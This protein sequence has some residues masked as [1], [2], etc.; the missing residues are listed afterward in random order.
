MS[1]GPATKPGSDLIHKSVTFVVPGA[2]DQPTGGYRYDGRVVTGLRERGWRVDVAE[3]DGR[4]PDPDDIA[5][6]SLDQALG[7]AESG[8]IVIVDGLA[9]SGLPDVVRR[10]SHRLTILALIHHALA[11][12]AGV[13]TTN[14]Q[15]WIEPERRA[16]A[17]VS[18]VVTTS[19]YTANRLQ[20]LGL[21]TSA[22]HV[23]APGVDAR[24]PATPSLDPPI[25]L[26][27]VASIIPRKNHAGL[28]DALAGIR[29]LDW[30]CHLAGSLG[31]SPETVSEVLDRVKRHALEQR[32]RLDGELTA[33]ALDSVYRQTDLFVLASR[34]EGFGMVVT[35]A[36]A[37]GLPLVTTTG[38]ALR[39]TVPEKA[40]LTV[41]P[42]DTEALASALRRVLTDGNLFHSLKA[43]ATDARRRLPSWQSCAADFQQVLLETSATND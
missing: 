21:L 16:L 27:C 38:G 25:N 42:D 39:D 36:L 13:E 3:L 17:S 23:V 40:A 24:P 14:G 26:C 31:Q 29:D 43:G 32:I 37:Y 15:K 11:D 35:E 6:H 7:T 9:L 28:V 33:N 18:A 12:E 20:T 2:L 5:A 19:A 1:P 8:R 30:H 10:H 22:P 41:N 4:F 34:F